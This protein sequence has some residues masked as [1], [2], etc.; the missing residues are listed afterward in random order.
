MNKYEYMYRRLVLKHEPCSSFFQLW[1]QGYM[2]GHLPTCECGLCNSLVRVCHVIAAGGPFVA[3]G[4]RAADRVR[5]LEGE[6][7]DLLSLVDGSRSFARKAGPPF[8]GPLPHPLPGCLPP[9]PGDLLFLHVPI[10]A[11]G[12]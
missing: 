8:P 3:F 6:L 9:P 5:L 11:C 2:W 4:P 1:L 12:S 10:G 7:R